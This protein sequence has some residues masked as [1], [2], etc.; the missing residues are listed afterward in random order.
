MIFESDVNAGDIMREMCKNILRHHQV[1][2]RIRDALLNSNKLSPQSASLC[3]DEVLTRCGIDLSTFLAEKEKSGKSYKQVL[4]EVRSFNGS[5]CLKLN[6]GIPLAQLGTP[7][8]IRYHILMPHSK[9]NNI[10]KNS[11]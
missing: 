2:P 1:D 8:L 11:N 5:I 9:L 3:R 4:E 10:M 7:H 6:F